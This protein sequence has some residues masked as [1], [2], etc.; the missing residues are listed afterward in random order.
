MQYFLLIF[1]NRID[2]QLRSSLDFSQKSRGN[3][4]PVL[5]IAEFQNL[6]MSMTSVG[7]DLD[8][9]VEGYDPEDGKWV[10]ANKT[11]RN[12]KE[13][14]RREP[15]GKNEQGIKDKS[16]G[17]N[18]DEEE[19]GMHNNTQLQDV[20]KSEGSGGKICK[21]GEGGK[22]C[23][24][25][26][27]QVVC[28]EPIEDDDSV[29]FCLKCG[30]SFHASC[31]GVTKSALLALRRYDMLCFL[32]SLCKDNLS[33]NGTNSLTA[34]EAKI[35][36]LETLI[37]NNVQSL[38]KF[39]AVH[40]RQRKLFET[41]EEESPMQNRSYAEAVKGTCDEVLKKVTEKIKTLTKED[42]EKREENLV[43][44]NIPE[45]KSAS[46]DVRQRYDE[47]SFSNI[48]HAL[49]G[50]GNDIEVSK[51]YRLG[52]RQE[53]KNRPGDDIG[54]RGISKPR[55]L[56]VKLKRKEDAEHLLRLRWYLKDVGFPNIYMTRDLPPEER[57]VQRKLREEL[58][59]KGKDT[60]RIFRGQVVPKDQRRRHS[61]TY[62][63]GRYEN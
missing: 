13:K 47:D 14:E 31:Q 4:Y 35:A 49:L 61:P 50:E 38:D 55:L 25:G 42:Q 39:V 9:I 45:S 52:K 17:E 23:K 44:H 3:K 15:R 33:Q 57:E 40:E 6:K 5:S 26:P 36:K 20:A 37:Q 62:S 34:I 59:M 7:E 11:K 58:K 43:L 29:V 27:K 63:S 30:V 53:S 16:A 1:E 60:H 8:S 51:T 46:A 32:C 18:A 41:A 28:E 54:D 22:I 10:T 21:G 48:V 2:R 19:Q 24:G 56:L 12:K